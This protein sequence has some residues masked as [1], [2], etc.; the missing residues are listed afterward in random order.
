MEAQEDH[1]QALIP[2]TIVSQQR[3]P[4]AWKTGA[5][6][7]WRDTRSERADDQDDK[8]TQGTHV[9]RLRPLLAFLILFLKVA[10]A[11]AVS[12]MRKRDGP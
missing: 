2:L 9:W 4:A 3:R 7:S 5:L 12:L 11:F 8:G 6:A 1:I 10:S